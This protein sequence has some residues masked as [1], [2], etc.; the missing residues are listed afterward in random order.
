[1]SAEGLHSAAAIQTAKNIVTELR[2]G[3]YD[4]VRRLLEVLNKQINDAE[5]A[6]YSP[7]EASGEHADPAL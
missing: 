2:F 5:V 3:R 6:S 4:N 1:M 7:E